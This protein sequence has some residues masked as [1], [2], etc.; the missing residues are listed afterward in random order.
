MRTLFC[1]VL[2]APLA[3]LAAASPAHADVQAGIS[4]GEGGVQGFYLAIGEYYDAPA[5]AV[6]AVHEKRKMP[7]EEIPVAYFIARRA[8]VSPDVV[9]KLRLGGK[10]WMEVSAH[11]GISTDVYYVP[12]KSDPGPP[13]GKAY[14]HF[15]NKKK[16]SRQ[17][18]VLSDD[19]IINLVNLRF[20]SEHY[21]CS[22]DEVIKMRSEGKSY[23]EISHGKGKSSK[24]S[25]T[26][27]KK[28]GHGKGR[29][30]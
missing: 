21:G 10:S 22:A 27:A 24:A 11:F 8:N 6:I 29:G 25:P 14:G 7:D 2:V 20:I 17:A 16:G 4:L 30:K 9:V 13:F 23:V 28:G 5:S 18:V 12:V 26:V 19:D 1:T 15:K 3:I